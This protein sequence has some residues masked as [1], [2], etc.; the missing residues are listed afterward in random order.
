M[1]TIKCGFDPSPQ[2]HGWDLL[3]GLGPTVLVTIGFDPTY[4]PQ[5][6]PHRSPHLPLPPLPAL[7][8]TGA[9]DNFIDRDLAM[10]LNLPIV[11]QRLLSGAHGAELVN[12]HLAQVCISALDYTIHGR[13]G[14]VD[15]SAGGQSHLALMGRTFLQHFTMVYEGRTGVVTLS[16]E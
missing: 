8:D 6:I 15:L 14:A 1:P 2:G 16:N 4:D 11:D 3:I 5:A 7:I 12:V 10:R 9:S 13:F